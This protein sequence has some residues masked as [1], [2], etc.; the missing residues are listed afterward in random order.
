M[1]VI[2]QTLNRT[3]TLPVTGPRLR[4][5]ISC[6]KTHRFRLGL[7]RGLVNRT[8]LDFGRTLWPPTSLYEVDRKRGS[9]RP[10]VTTS[11]LLYDRVYRGGGVSTLLRESGGSGGVFIVTKSTWIVR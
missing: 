2:Q 8:D 1:T 6:L 3:V 4:E 10:C 9:T 7:I 5:I 11:R